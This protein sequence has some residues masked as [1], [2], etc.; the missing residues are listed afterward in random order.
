MLTSIAPGDFVGLLVYA[1]PDETP[2]A[3]DLE[4]LRRRIATRTGCATTLG[5]GPRYLHSTGQLHKGGANTGV[6]VIITTPP[7]ADVPIPGSPYSF[8]VLEMAQAIERSL[9]TPRINPFFP[10]IG[11]P[12]FPSIAKEELPTSSK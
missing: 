9:A 3:D 8:G 11:K 7:T 6:Y 12:I 1:P 5:F 10:S 4:Q 2:L